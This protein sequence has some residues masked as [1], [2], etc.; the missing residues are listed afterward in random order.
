M[1]AEI[2]IFFN[3]FSETLK[4]FRKEIVE[5]VFQKLEKLDKVFS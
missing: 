5:T 4:Q 1:N 3:D 2:S